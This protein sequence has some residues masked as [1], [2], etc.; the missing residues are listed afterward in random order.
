MR[1]IYQ[2][3]KILARKLRSSSI[4]SLFTSVRRQ[5]HSAACQMSNI[6]RLDTKGTQRSR[7]ARWCN[8]LC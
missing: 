6:Y 8:L 4:N 7:A 2:I 1:I 3:N 5:Q